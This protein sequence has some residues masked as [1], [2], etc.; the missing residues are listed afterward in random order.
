MYTYTYMYMY[1]YM[2]LYLYM[3]TWGILTP[4]V[5]AGAGQKRL[6][7]A[8]GGITSSSAGLGIWRR[9]LICGQSQPFLGSLPA[10]LCP[11]EVC[12]AACCI[13]PLV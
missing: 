4:F 6:L 7:P 10:A 5:N 8:V 3:Y 12:P 13:L 2:Y 9:F 1:M 11:L